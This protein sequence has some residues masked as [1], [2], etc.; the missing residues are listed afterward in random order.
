M[1][2]QI[3]PKTKH[4]VLLRNP[5]TKMKLAKK[6]DKTKLGLVI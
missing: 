3:T 4:G 6:I 2:S 1:I 5:Q